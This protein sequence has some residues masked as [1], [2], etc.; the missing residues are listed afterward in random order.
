MP[1]PSLARRIGEVPCAAGVDCASR[2]GVTGLGG[3]G[4]VSPSHLPDALKRSLRARNVPVE[5][6]GAAVALLELASAESDRQSGVAVLVL[7]VGKRT[8][9]EP[10]QSRDFPFGVPDLHVGVFEGAIRELKA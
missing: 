3:L 10:L 6:A 8:A 4:W 7:A 2:A 1:R 9:P 5:T